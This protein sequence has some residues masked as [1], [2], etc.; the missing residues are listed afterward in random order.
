MKIAGIVAEYNPFHN[1]H[2]YQITQTRAAGATHIVAVMGGNYLQR[3]EAAQFEKHVRAR[4]ALC[5]GADLVLELP[6]PYAMATAEHF[7]TGALTLLQGLGCID[8]LSFGAESPLALLHPLADALLCDELP[9]LIRQHLAGGT[10]FARA[11][12]LALE[13]PLGKESAALLQSPN[14]ILAVEYLKAAKCLAFTP[15]LCAVARKG[16]AHD[17]ACPD[18][19]FASASHLRTLCGKQGLQALRP[20]VPPAAYDTYC[21]AWEQ[22]LIPADHTRTEAGILAVLRRMSPEE[23]ARLPDLSEG[24]EHRLYAA[25]R[26]SATVEELFAGVKSKRYPLARI[27]RLVFA[28]YLG[29][30]AQDALTAPPYL[31]VLGFNQNGLEILTRAKKTALLPLSSSLARLEAENAACRRF[32]LLESRATDLYALTLPQVQPCGFEYTC[33]AVVLK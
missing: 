20:F 26:R 16:A 28:A 10:T 18:G 24:L 19:T 32:A 21:A 15:E 2:A 22:R 12:Q 9:H 8:L 13:V 33:P 7:A 6:L 14:N 31:R 4:A 17:G 11:R 5:C 25:V 27:R 23:F 1:G 3:G 29:L 30:T